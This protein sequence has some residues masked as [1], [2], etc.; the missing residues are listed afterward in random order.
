MNRKV[1][2]TKREL[3]KFIRENF[4][5]DDSEFDVPDEWKG[6]SPGKIKPPLSASAAGGPPPK[7]SPDRPAAQPKMT[8]PK[9]TSVKQPNIAKLSDRGRIRSYDASNQ[10]A[11]KPYTKKE[12]RAG[13]DIDEKSP[14][15]L[16]KLKGFFGSKQTNDKDV[17]HR[18]AADQARREFEKYRKMYDAGRGKDVK[19]D[20]YAKKNMKRSLERWKLHRSLAGGR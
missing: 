13:V 3:S 19:R 12:L 4:E 14:S 16:D 2:I 5:N 10:T 8:S 11:K 7:P 15:F 17:N 1:C 9:S 6:V 20:A 18:T